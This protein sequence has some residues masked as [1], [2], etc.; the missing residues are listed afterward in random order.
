MKYTQRLLT[1]VLALGGLC[2]LLGT[3]APGLVSA[4]TPRPT[5]TPIPVK[6]PTTLPYPAYGTPAPGVRQTQPNPAVPTQITLQQAIDIAAAKSPILAAARADY[7]IST[8][9]VQLAKSA[10][11]PNVAAVGSIARSNGGRSGGSNSGTG[12][13]TTTL[14][15][16]GSTNE[17]LQLT[18]RQLIFDGGKTVAL[19]H[20]ARATEAAAAGTYERN[21]QLLSFNVAQAYYNALQAQAATQLAARVV[22][23]NVVQENLIRAQIRAGTEARASLLAAEVPTAQARVAL[24]RA[25]GTEISADAAFANELGL[26]ANTAVLP[27]NDTP[28][29]AA[30]SLL[31]VPV[32]GYDTAVTRAL[33]LR[34]DYL[35]SQHTVDAAKY[36]LRAA[37]LGRFPTL[38]GTAD[39]GTSSTTPNGGDF[40]SSNSIGASLNIPIF[41][42]GVTAAQSA[43]AQYQLDKA[44]AQLESTRIGLE[45]NVRQA[46]AGLISS[47]AATQQTAVELAN[48]TEQVKATQAQY[49]AGVT[50]LPLL[51]QA[52]LGLTQAE[53]DRLNAVYLL[54]Q[55][56]QTY[57]FAIGE[58][59]LATGQPATP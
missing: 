49:R 8:V 39:A 32:L 1:G 15:S 14:G 20:S 31:K 19:I 6:S 30:A 55:S 50:N 34:P 38:T 33:A 56:E 41:D 52:Q 5:P 37:K 29:G 17:S 12:G 57:L 24:V 42:Q 54:R 2:A 18:L 40:R 53:T 45:L 27:V 7:N 21:L 9:P 44:N 16:S 58:S 4:A 43:Q 48:A 22:Q 23:Q 28:A 13:S 10:I 11:F 36:S 46:L 47:Q 25:Q 51:L 35:A 59:D 26:D 3:G